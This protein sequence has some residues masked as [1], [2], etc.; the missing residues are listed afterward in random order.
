MKSFYVKL[1]IIYL[2]SGISDVE[3]ALMPFNV[4]GKVPYKVIIKTHILTQK[5]SCSAAGS[6]AYK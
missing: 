5:M 2:Q 4:A 6:V 3:Y 1:F